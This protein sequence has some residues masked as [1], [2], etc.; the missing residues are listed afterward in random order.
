[1]I[2][3]VIGKLT[4][5]EQK[6]I[7]RIKNMAKKNEKNKI[8]SIIIVHNLAQ[9]HKIK[10]VQN[11]I[12]NLLQKSATFDLTSNNY[13]GDSPEFQGRDYFVET[14]DES[15]EIRVFHYL[16][17]KEGTE[18]GDYYNEFTLELIKQQFNIY[19]GRKPRNIPDEIINLFSELSTDIMG[20]KMECEKTGPEQNIIKLKENQNSK[21]KKRTIHVQN[22]F[23]DQDGNYLK[24]KGKF[25]PKYSLYFYKEKQ[26]SNNEDDD[27]CDVEYN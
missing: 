21:R 22:T 1:M 19:G 13:I 3:L 12:D 11:H 4:R 26:T 17:A 2:I 18:A 9:Y 24:N 27:D 8:K 16:M 20:E 23:I 25:E 15:E 5:T 6:L 7:T 14:S 10:E